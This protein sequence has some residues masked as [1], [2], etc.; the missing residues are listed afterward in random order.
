MDAELPHDDR[1]PPKGAQPPQRNPFA[2]T[3]ARAA[4]PASLAALARTFQGSFGTGTDAEAAFWLLLRHVLHSR[5]CAERRRTGWIPDEDVADLCS[6]KSLNLV[7]RIDEGKWDPASSRPAELASYLTVVARNALID[8]L[9]RVAHN[10]EM[11]TQGR[12]PQRTPVH[13]EAP[14]LPVQRRRFVEQLVACVR[15]LKPLQ[16]RIWFF[17]V[18]LDMPSRLIASHPEVNLKA[19]HVDVIQQRC[20]KSVSACMRARGFDAHEM[21]PGTFTELWKMFRQAGVDGPGRSR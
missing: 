5:L 10:E 20:R 4:W 15:A 9:R 11:A 16:Q 1:F 14:D 12:P 17:R 7:R 3:S 6:E 8:H 2:E 13:L 19:A 21:P 18:M